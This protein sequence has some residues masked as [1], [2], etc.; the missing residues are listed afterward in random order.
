MP[1]YKTIEIDTT[2]VDLADFAIANGINYK[3]LKQLNPWLRNTS[4]PDKSRRKYILKIAT[5]PSLLV[6]KDFETSEQKK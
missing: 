2:I 6:F 4:L 3:L 1:K 5:D